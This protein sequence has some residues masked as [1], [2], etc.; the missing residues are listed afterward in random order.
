MSERSFQNALGWNGVEICIPLSTEIVWQSS[1]TQVDA[2]DLTKYLLRRFR[3]K[4]VV[5]IYVGFQT[6]GSK[7]R[8]KSTLQATRR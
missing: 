6:K 2:D 1:C 7:A 8:G 4:E 5:C 3:S